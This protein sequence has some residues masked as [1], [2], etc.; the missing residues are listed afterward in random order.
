M[1]RGEREMEK[2]MKRRELVQA[3]LVT[4]AALAL[5]GSTAA[6]VNAEEEEGTASI[7]SV[8]DPTLSHVPASCISTWHNPACPGNAAYFTGCGLSGSTCSCGHYQ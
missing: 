8:S 3:G 5:G 6:S 4:G 7:Q 2:K 1:T